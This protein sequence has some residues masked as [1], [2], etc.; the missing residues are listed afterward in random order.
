MSDQTRRP[1]IDAEK[2][3]KIK[4]FINLAR[5]VDNKVD[6]IEHIPDYVV[7][8]ASLISAHFLLPSNAKVVDVG[9]GNGQV[10]YAMA[11]LNPLR[12]FIG[13]DHD[14][15]MIEHAKNL[16]RLP[17]LTFKHS[18]GRLQDFEDE[19][20]D[21]IINS[22]FLHEI[23]SSYNRD[24]MMLS[25][26]LDAQIKK[27]KPGG[28]MLIRDYM[29]PPSDEYVLLELPDFPSVGKEPQDLSYADL[30]IDYS[31]TARPMENGGAEGFYLE[32]LDPGIL[33]ALNPTLKKVGAYEMTEKD[34]E[35]LGEDFTF[36]EDNSRV[37]RLLHKWAVEFIH[38]KDERQKWRHNL[39]RE[40]TFFTDRDYR[41]VLAQ[42][43]MRFIFSAPYRNPWVVDHFYK[44]KFRLYTEDAH[45]MPPPA[46]N[47]FIVAQKIPDQM[48]LILDERRPSQQKVENLEVITVRDNKRGTLQ[49]VAR[50]PGEHCDIIPWRTAAD[51]RLV[52]YVRSG[53]PRPIINAVKR[54]NANLDSKNWSGHL[55]EPITMDTDALT[56]NVIENKDKIVQYTQDHADLEIK[57]KD[58]LFV[59][60]IF[61]PAPDKIDEAIEPVF[62][63]VK[64]PKASTWDIGSDQTE[65]GFKFGGKIVELDANDII[66]AAQVGLLP[67]PRLELHVL[68]LMRRLGI[69]PPPWVTG[70]IIVDRF[71]TF[72]ENEVPDILQRD[73]ILNLEKLI[74]EWEQ[75]GFATERIGGDHLKTT[76]SVFVEEGKFGGGMRGMASQDYEFL[77]TDDGVENIA[78]VM[79]LTR[80]WDDQLMVGVEVGNM[81]V[82]QRMGGSGLMI[83]A[84]TFVIPRDVRTIADAKVFVGKQ[85][86]VGPENVFQVGES[87][88]THTG[89]TPQRVYPFAVADARQAETHTGWNYSAAKRIGYLIYA[90]EVFSG[91]FVKLYTRVQ[92]MLGAE[93]GMSPDRQLDNKHYKN[94]ELNT[95]KTQ[96]QRPGENHAPLSRVLGER[97]NTGSVPAQ[98]SYDQKKTR[99]T[100]PESDKT[101]VSLRKKPTEKLSL[102]FNP[103][104]K[105]ENVKNVSLSASEDLKKSV[106]GVSESISDKKEKKKPTLRATRPDP[107]L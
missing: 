44:G 54:G 87:Y 17:N 3:S 27:L 41:R 88:F 104:E 7:Q 74:D 101:P 79:P 89:V 69:E 30:L 65:T 25:E 28:I 78:V 96:V 70:E 16:Y 12:N 19:A 56:R 48:S 9:C 60:Q 92:M 97:D 85:F 18:D 73:N 99:S 94:F 32:E 67:E 1:D 55:I 76:R 51:G 24:P 26:F 6:K 50:R 58:N 22:N 36:D 46:T 35:R 64:K 107:N 84:P 80:G 29:M 98:R 102:N 93:H 37:F 33:Q 95:D 66:R 52:I 53:Y 8:K 40:Y 100:A 83:T 62:I 103:E 31:Q 10:T 59:G 68:D 57:G 86:G 34:K 106:K 38:K 42:F 15:A 61:Y 45:L 39:D 77:V 21:G 14:R 90:F 72:D 20:L 43:G 11:L 23:Y 105:E 91:D 5:G 81:A 4:D 75:D 2:A 71:R 13:I 82:P 47:Y 63:E 49:E